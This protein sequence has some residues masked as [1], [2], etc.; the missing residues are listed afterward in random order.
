MPVITIEGQPLHYQIRGT[1]FPVLLGH[2]YLWDS[3]MWA[4]QIDALSAS[5]QTI[6]PDLWGHGR[7]GQM[8]ADTRTL[9]DL[10]GHVIKLLDALDIKRC[11]V[12]G[13]SVGGM[14]G[15]EL[16]LLQPDRVR[17]LVMMDTDLGAEP[18]TTRARYFQMLDTIE[19][20]GKIPPPMIDAIVPLFFRPEAALDGD[21][22]VSF[23]DALAR[24]S[25][26]QLRQSIVPLGRLIFSRPDAVS[27]LASLDSVRTLLMCG[28]LDFTRTPAETIRMAEVIG[29]QHVLV[30]DAG[31]ISNLENVEFVTN[32]LL[33]WLKQRTDENR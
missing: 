32:N 14:W 4:P 25:P 2:S 17:A 29:C 31:H 18:D 27:R 24:F 7:S 15:A 9:G 33:Q 10:A 23:R 26:A 21:V 20:L 1:G 19:T 28:A 5:F 30:P 3:S 22:P 13:L 16:A 11:A 6:A 12:V 8:P